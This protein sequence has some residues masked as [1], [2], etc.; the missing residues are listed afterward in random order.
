MKD[1]SG[2][3]DG[4]DS[5]RGDGDGDGGGPSPASPFGSPDSV[6]PILQSGSMA[7][8]E[9]LIHRIEMRL[10][11]GSGEGDPARGPYSVITVYVGTDRGSIEMTYDRGFLGPD[12][13]G[14]AARLVSENLGPAA[15]VMRSI[16]ALRE[17]TGAG[18]A[19]RDR[20][21]FVV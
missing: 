12:P 8:D 2:R 15:L 11:A 13:L 21:V 9:F 1:G 10:Y 7:Q 16:I 3:G 5:N 17:R 14:N 6:L 4:G 19:P 18:A 20:T